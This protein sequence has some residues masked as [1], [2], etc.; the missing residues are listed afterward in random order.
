MDKESLDMLERENER[1]KKEA[2][3]E[4]AKDRHKKKDKSPCKEKEIRLDDN[5]P[6]TP[7]SSSSFPPPSTSINSDGDGRESENEGVGSGFGGADEEAA[8]EREGD[9]VMRITGGYGQLFQENV[10]AFLFSYLL[11]CVYFSLSI[12]IRLMTVDWN[13]LFPPLFFAI[14]GYWRCTFHK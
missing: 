8:E 3:G 6:Q 14:E 4:E 11:M 1:M 7:F 12:R 5:S 13:I 10:F 9:E 2:S